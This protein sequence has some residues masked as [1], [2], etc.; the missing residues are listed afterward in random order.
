MRKDL[1][2]NDLLHGVKVGAVKIIYSDLFIAIKKKLSK[3][4]TM[5][6]TKC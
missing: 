4:N 3:K 5:H 2:I 1:T 6:M